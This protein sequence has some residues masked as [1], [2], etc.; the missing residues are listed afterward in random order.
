MYTYF[1]LAGLLVS[2]CVALP[3]NIN[4]GAYSPALVVGDGEIS[5]GGKADVAGLMNALEGA[6]VSGA[7]AN[8]AAR[9]ATPA[10]ATAAPA[11]VEAAVVAEPEIVSIQ[12]PAKVAAL[13]GVGKEIAPRIVSLVQNN[14]KI[15]K[16]SQ[17]DSENGAANG[18]KAR[19]ESSV[20]P[21]MKTTVTTMIVRGG[22]LP[23][24]VK[25]RSTVDSLERRSSP[26][27]LEGVNLNMAEGQVAELTFV[28]TREVDG[29]EADNDND[30]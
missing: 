15:Q 10:Q 16:K 7:A 1:V 5:F 14:E 22:A 19:D 21:R 28:E 24:G 29:D 6:A 20:T 30:N 9:P 11:P 8:E 27:S 3:L 25:E 4:L 13:Q 18:V 23:A 17:S 2:N 26:S 12:Q